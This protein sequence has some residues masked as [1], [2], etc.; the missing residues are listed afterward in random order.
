[1][2]GGPYCWIPRGKDRKGKGTRE[3][4]GEYL[5]TSREKGTI[6]FILHPLI[7]ASF[8]FH[9]RSLVCDFQYQKKGMAKQEV[10]NVVFVLF[11]GVSLVDS[12]GNYVT[13]ACIEKETLRQQEVEAVLI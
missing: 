4:L 13:A 11:R 8:P 7:Q 5:A 10:G 9:L 1:M 6:A 2:Y 3:R 12:M